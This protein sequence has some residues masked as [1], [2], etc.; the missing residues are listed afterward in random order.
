M[1]EM[2]DD[3]VH[4]LRVFIANDLNDAHRAGARSLDEQ[5]EYVLRG[6]LSTPDFLACLIDAL[7]FRVLEVADDGSAVTK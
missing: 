3:A 5:A 4:D 2:S 1:N 6:C 7:G